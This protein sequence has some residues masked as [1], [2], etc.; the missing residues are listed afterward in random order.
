LTKRI[1]REN[2]GAFECYTTAVNTNRPMGNRI[3]FERF[4]DNLWIIIFAIGILVI[5]IGS[6]SRV[7][8]KSIATESKA[9]DS[10]C[11]QWAC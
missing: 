4:A 6:W 7:Y 8:F 1:V 3:L 11:Q 5:L 2:G 10:Q 9:E